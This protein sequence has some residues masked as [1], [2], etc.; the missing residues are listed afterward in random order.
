MKNTI[1]RIFDLIKKGELTFM[2]K[3][4]S[5]RVLSTTQAFGLKRDLHVSF[6]KPEA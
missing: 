2:I 5:K 1:L 4:I 6:P 3:G